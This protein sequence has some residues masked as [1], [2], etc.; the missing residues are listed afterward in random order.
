M[1]RNVRYDEL[2]DIHKEIDRK[3][4]DHD[5]VDELNREDNH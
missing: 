4:I 2:T 1:R 5:D 3:T